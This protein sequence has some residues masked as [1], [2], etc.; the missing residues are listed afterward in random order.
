MAKVPTVPELKKALTRERRKNKRL[1]A[2]I[3]QL[4][5]GIQEVSE[6]VVANKRELDVQLTRLAHLQAEVDLLKRRS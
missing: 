1:R 6:G 3:D 5:E 4:Q 2:V